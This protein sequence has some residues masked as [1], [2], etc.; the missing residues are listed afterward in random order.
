MGNLSGTSSSATCAPIEA[1][2]TTVLGTV[3]GYE[4]TTDAHELLREMLDRRV[5]ELTHPVEER[6]SAWRIVSLVAK[7]TGG[8][9]VIVRRP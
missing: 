8:L 6:T 1:T 5:I 4:S 2:Y 7:A 3:V 9:Q